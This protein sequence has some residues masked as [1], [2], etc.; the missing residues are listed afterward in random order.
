MVKYC[1][2]REKMLV[3]TDEI[4]KEI[5]R[6]RDEGYGYKKIAR[7]LNLN[8]STVK[9]YCQKNGLGGVR[10]CK[11]EHLN[12]KKVI[13]K[14]SVGSLIT[15]K[16]KTCGK[17]F[18]YVY[19]GGKYKKYCSEKCR[20]K[21]KPVEAKE[22][23][24]E[25]CGKTFVA[26]Y[27]RRFCSDR[28]RYG[29]YKK[30]L[31]GTI[32]VCKGCGKEFTVNKGTGGYCSNKCYN[33]SK[34]KSHYEFCKELLEV[35][36]GMIVP[37]EEYKGSDHL[38]KCKCLKCG[39]EIER[40]ARK[41]VGSYKH[42]CPYCKNRSHG[43]EAIAEWL[44][45]YGYEYVRQYTNDELKY[46]NN[47]FYD[48]AIIENGKPIMFIEYDGEQHFKPVDA[49]GGEEKFME[50]IIR[51]E[52]KNNYAAEVGVPLLRISYKQK[53]NIDDILKRELG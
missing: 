28:C 19:N 1:M 52:I 13:N 41:Y 44:D 17:S 25:K 32:K 30:K 33:E 5:A 24:C 27:K 22:Q 3:L 9:K 7:G 34:R 26:K 47:L 38:L 14:L 10:G 18:E 31:K 20:Y 42:G 12:T 21:Y 40:V 39:N 45:E 4:K 48:F 50:N 15:A 35:H 11:E 49:L 29:A 53:K 43:E 8:L 51:D 46:F 37:L 2:G 6:L 23:I 36:K 16:C